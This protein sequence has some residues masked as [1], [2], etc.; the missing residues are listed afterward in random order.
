MKRWKKRAR[1]QLV[2]E[3]EIESEDGDPFSSSYSR[4]E[5]QISSPTKRA[6]FDVAVAAVQ[7]HQ[8]Q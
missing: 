8:L 5:S 1:G 7:P 6:K 4:G 3:D 2:L